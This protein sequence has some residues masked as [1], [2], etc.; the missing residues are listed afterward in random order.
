MSHWHFTA[1]EGIVI[2]SVLTGATGFLTGRT[3][4]KGQRLLTQDQRLWEKR[5][6][7]YVELTKQTLNTQV[8]MLGGFG[9]WTPDRNAILQVHYDEVLNDVAMVQAFASDEIRDQ[10]DDY[11]TATRE[12]LLAVE[13]AAMKNASYLSTGTVGDYPAWCAQLDQKLGLE[14]K[15]RTHNHTQTGLLK[16]LRAELQFKS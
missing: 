3:T 10:W 7:L 11:V 9:K 13:Q 8:R 15:E 2:G 5:S 14:D 1:V 16:K 4:L 6:D 12:L